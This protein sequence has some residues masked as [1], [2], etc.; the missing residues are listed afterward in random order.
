MRD[1]ARWLRDNRDR[2]GLL[3]SGWSAEHLGERDKP[4]YWDDFWGLAGLYEAARLAERI[5]APEAGELWGAFDDLK[6][7]TA[8]S[9]R[10]VLGEQQ[11]RGAWETYIPTGPGDVG[12]RDSTM[13]GTAAYFHPLRL[14]MG[15]KLGDDIDRGGALHARHHVRALRHRRLPARRRL[16]RVRALSD[17]AVGARLPARR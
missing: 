11:R 7:A 2:Y 17:H 9:I 8:E 1:A 14:H 5:G 4:H 6:R 16:E 10:W 13:I 3:H 12:R 15:S